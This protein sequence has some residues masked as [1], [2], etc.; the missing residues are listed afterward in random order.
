MLS[1]NS[2]IASLHSPEHS[3]LD[4]C[5]NYSGNDEHK[6]TIETLQFSQRYIGSLGKDLD[7][8]GK[9]GLLAKFVG[10]LEISLRS[11]RIPAARRD[12]FG[13]W[14][15]RCHISLAFF[16]VRREIERG[17]LLFVRKLRG[18]PKFSR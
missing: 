3:S 8:K 12:R 7:V 14:R 13:W 4:A 6:F 11:H 5:R 10:T 16:I 2:I 17:V 9:T 15:P 18:A 1:E